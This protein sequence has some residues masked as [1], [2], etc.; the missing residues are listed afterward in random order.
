M[1]ETLYTLH[2]TRIDGGADTGEPETT[3]DSKIE[4]LTKEQLDS[5]LYTMREGDFGCSFGNFR[6]EEQ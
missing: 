2:Y 1:T 5:A 6:T 3:E 4:N